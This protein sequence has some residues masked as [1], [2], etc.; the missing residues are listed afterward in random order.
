M[1]HRK[2]EEYTLRIT[3]IGTTGEGIGHL[4]DGY[5]LFVQGALPGDTICAHIIK[6]QKKYGIARLVDIIE[7]S[8]DRITP[9]CP[10]ADKCGGCQISA[11]S[12][13]AQLRYKE[14]KVRELLVRVGGFSESQ[15]SEVFEGI[16]GYYDE[17]PGSRIE[18]TEVDY[19]SGYAPTRFRNKAQYPVGTDRDG[20]TVTGFYVLHSHRIVPCTDCLI[21]AESD[22]AILR[23]IRE[24]MDE[25]HVSAYDETT[26][27]GLVRHVLIRTGYE[28]HEIQVCIVINGDEIPHADKLCDRICSVTDTRKHDQ[29]VVSICTS[30]NIDDT[31]VILGSSYNVIYG[32]EHITDRIDDLEFRISALS[33]YQVNPIQ[34]RK[35]YAK[36]LEYAGLTGTETVW[37]LY[38]GIGTISLFLARA[39]GRVYGVEVIPQAIDNARE[40]A[41]ING[42]D[43]VEFMV[44][45][46]EE[47]LPEFYANAT[48]SSS[49]SAVHPDVIVVDPPRKGC[50]AACL[51]TMLRMKPDR[52]V[53]VSCD[54]ATL[55]R[56]LQILCADGTYRLTHA[57]CT[58]MFSGSVHIESVCRLERQIAIN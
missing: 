51:D 48:G 24:F 31:N 54:P 46:A 34:T 18:T 29:H 30:T 41:R 27:Q 9:A 58:D 56:D 16:I 35:L 6:A 3:D 5:T 11:L 50:D 8:P 26:G 36:A 32:A 33:F 17:R 42:I 44:G 7:P 21:G 14:R 47:V 39:T 38:C 1:T 52:I 43:N 37:D 15:V 22:A 13:E 40:N 28:T 25:Y 19:R 4:D 49:E 2:N 53:Y 12:Y 55:A 10:L 20:H 23:A 45:R 57:S